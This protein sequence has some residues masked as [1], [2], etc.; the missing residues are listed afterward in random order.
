MRS[1]CSTASSHDR[2]R[3]ADLEFCSSDWTRTS[4]HP[5]D[6]RRNNMGRPRPIGFDSTRDPTSSDN[7]CA[8]PHRTTL[9]DSG[10]HGPD[11]VCAE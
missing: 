4:N 9:F 1:L 7:P 8:H 3:V 6:L 2:R 10:R 5:S 11:R